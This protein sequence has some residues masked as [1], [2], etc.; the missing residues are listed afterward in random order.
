VLAPLNPVTV[1]LHPLV[2]AVAADV[3]WNIVVCEEVAFVIM[4]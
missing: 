3:I 2:I 4:I 1:K